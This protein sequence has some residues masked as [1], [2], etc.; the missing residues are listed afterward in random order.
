MSGGLV[1]FGAYSFGFLREYTCNFGDGVPQTVRLPNMHGGWNENGWGVLPQAIGVVNCGFRLY[2]TTRAEMD[3]LR[4]AVW[5]MR[6]YGL[7]QLI[8][9]PTLLSDTQRFCYAQIHNISMSERKD[10]HTDLIQDVRVIFHVPDPHWYADDDH[11]PWTF[12]DG[13]AFDDP[14]LTFGDGGQDIVA[15]G[16]STSDTIMNDGTARTICEVNINPGAGNT[17]TD[18]TVERVVDGVVKDRVKFTG[19]LNGDV[20]FNINGWVQRVTNG[21]VDAWDDFSYMNADFFRLE[22]GSNTIRVL[23]A[24]AGDDAT[25]TLRFWDAFL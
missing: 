23:M 18:P 25:V 7:A 4:D 13:H 3:A 21:G 15:S 16:T 12:A 22:P 14:G 1:S 8:K 19:T 10:E 2:A 11:S 17:C 20:D 9:Q 5:L 24:N 6:S